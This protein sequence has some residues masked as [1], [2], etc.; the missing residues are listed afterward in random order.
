MLKKIVLATSAAAVVLGAGTAALAASGGGASPAPS[1]SGKS[2]VAPGAAAPDTAARG[3]KARKPAV[4]ALGRALHA[5]WVT[6]DRGSGNG[7]VTHDAIRGEVTAVS[8]TSIT[9]KALDG[10]SQTYAVTDATKV[11]HRKAAPG[12][13]KGTA[14]TISDV[15]TGDQ[16]AVAGTGATSLTAE[17]V[18][19]A[20]E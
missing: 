10:V 16:V 18:V 15:H 11:R 8:A 2:S 6:R 4:R 9:V 19:D 14:G 5:Q 7:F 13:G 12:A 20:T 1:A 17:H 3:E